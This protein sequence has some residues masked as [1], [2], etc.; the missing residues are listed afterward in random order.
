M[1]VKG[2]TG[3]WLLVIGRQYPVDKI[4]LKHIHEG[5][6]GTKETRGHFQVYHN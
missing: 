1:L 5:D 2:A 3:A 6:Q 4:K